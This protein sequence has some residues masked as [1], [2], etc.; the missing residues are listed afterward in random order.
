MKL[1]RQA[2]IA[3]GIAGAGMVGHLNAEAL[4]EGETLTRKQLNTLLDSLAEK[5]ES[6][7]SQLSPGASCYAPYPWYGRSEYV[8]PL[9]KKKTLHESTKEAER[10]EALALIGWKLRLM[11]KHV[12]EINALEVKVW[13]DETDLCS[14]CQRDKDKANP[15]IYLLVSTTSENEKGKNTRT[16]ITEDDLRKLI[17]FLK[18]QDR[19]KN[20][21][22]AEYLLKPELPRIR[23]ILGLEEASK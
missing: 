12:E 5:T 21:Y 6:S 16:S 10:K 1:S 19:W 8:C 22:D 9:C 2:L 17:A 13:L 7:K 4:A 18:K 20:Y 11:R 3:L 23:Q 14:H 15:D